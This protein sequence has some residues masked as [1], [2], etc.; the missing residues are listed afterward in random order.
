LAA[1]EFSREVRKVG[2]L[3]TG[4]ENENSLQYNG[5]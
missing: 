3:F 5:A 2:W 1:R 4:V